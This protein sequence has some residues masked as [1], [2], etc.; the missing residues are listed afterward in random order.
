MAQLII[1]Q[2][3]EIT[4][5][6]YLKLCMLQELDIRD[7]IASHFNNL[8]KSLHELQTKK[9][10]LDNNPAK[11]ALEIKLIDSEE[12]DLIV[13][14]NKDDNVCDIPLSL[15]GNYDLIWK[16]Y[17]KQEL[18]YSINRSN[19]QSYPYFQK[20]INKSLEK[21]TKNFKLKDDYFIL[22]VSQIWE[23]S[24]TIYPYECPIYKI[25][26]E[27]KTGEHDI[28]YYNPLKCTFYYDK[29]EK[30]A[31]SNKSQTKLL[32]LLPGLNW[33][34]LPETIK[35]FISKRSQTCYLYE[36]KLKMGIP[37]L[38]EKMAAT[39]NG[40]DIAYGYKIEVPEELSTST[41]NAFREHLAE[42]IE[43]S[44]EN[45][46][47]ENIKNIANSI[48]TILQKLK[49][50]DTDPTRIPKIKIRNLV[51]Y[52][53][54]SDDKKEIDPFF[55]DPDIIKY[56]DLSLIDFTNANIEG[57]D[58]SD[59]N[60]NIILDKLYNKSIKNTKLRNVNLMRQ[61][62]DGILAD[63]ADLRGTN[64]FVS[65][66]KTSIIGTVFSKSTT[67]MLETKILT[68]GEVQE[69]GIQ[70]EKEEAENFESVLRL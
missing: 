33:E 63:G 62:L 53:Y 28:Y 13:F 9:V 43:E 39:I 35:D 36:S 52:S 47:N 15:S 24:F 57:F 19:S 32:S 37:S 44:K 54:I 51:F 45:K 50:N 60:A 55:N 68:E 66:E 61:D 59:T 21:I 25:D 34:D 12:N 41:E 4:F 6:D 17:D 40:Q 46:K 22:R 69:L 64:I 67:S 7:N 38:L 20:V 48:K 70:V 30:K 58:L 56:C 16:Y 2:N 8:P 14:I 11:I 23:E 5:K 31:L 49:E 27:S 42:E 3:K 29:K 26:I 1:E 10:K 65:I 18:L